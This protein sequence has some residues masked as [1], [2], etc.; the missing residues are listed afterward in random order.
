[1][2]LGRA[3]RNKGPQIGALVW[4]FGLGGIAAIISF[5]DLEIGLSAAA[6]L[7]VGF[8]SIVI[9]HQGAAT[10]SP[11]VTPEEFYGASSEMQAQTTLQS[12]GTTWVMLGNVVVACMFLGQSLGLFALWMVA[13][14]SAAFLLMSYRVKRVRNALRIDHTLHSFLFEA[15]G[16]LGMRRLAALI[17]IFVGF[18]VF[19]AEIIAG[20]AL[21]VAIVPSPQG[22][23]IA[24]IL[25]F[26]LVVVMCAAAAAGG[27]R[28]VIVTDWTLWFLVIAAVSILG[29]VASV[30][31]V[32]TG[33][34]MLG[35]DWIPREPNWVGIS[36]FFVGV[37][38]LQVP[39]LLGDYGTWQRIKATRPTQ[40]KG[41]AS[42]TAKQAAYQA[43]LW[44]IPV[45]GG[46][47]VLA[48]PVVAK[49]QGGNIY[50]S[51]A[52]L[53]E[54]V[55]HWTL[56]GSIPAGWRVFLIV[57][58]AAGLLAVMAT[59][60]NSYLIVAMETWVRDLR[61]ILEDSIDDDQGSGLVRRGR[62]VCA[63]MALLACIPVILLVN[64][65]INLLGFIVIV[66]SVQVALAPAAVL[67]LYMRRT[68]RQMV[69]I[70]IIS[71]S[72]SFAFSLIYGFAVSYGP[73]PEPVRTYGPFLTAVMA[74]A[75]P[76]IAICA[77]LRN[78][79]R[80]WRIVRAYLWKLLI[81]RP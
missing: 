19:A 18:G 29:V 65:G 16:S 61:P 8:L 33:H 27:L 41:L 53:M 39:L 6:L 60:A 79:G 20:I 68:S 26:L 15:Y 28:A 4:P 38:A 64:R 42:H 63:I 52:P 23:V 57:P 51:S 47:A 34:S 1:M 30:P 25:V 7:A 11:H 78:R 80:S 76:T 31:L 72:G 22:S 37:T 35:L 59:T 2:N 3:I 14:W 24:P 73:W 45:F 54:I 71:T 21:L 44:G 70:V 74:L 10:Y 49:V 81:P 58:F 46:I 67:A 12:L 55:R 66:F 75:I 13:T 62:A 50:P 48:L 5:W 36:I 77:G 56:L 69:K 9:V 17:T 40:T 32:A 43:Y